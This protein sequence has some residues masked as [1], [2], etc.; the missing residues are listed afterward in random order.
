M[1]ELKNALEKA[2]EEAK[3][4]INRYEWRKSNGT[5][6]RMMDMSKDELQK[7][8]DH[9]WSMLYNKSRH[10]PGKV[11]LRDSIN[12]LG[13]A[14]LTELFIRFLLYECDIENM[15]TKQ[16]I[17]IWVSEVKRNSDV[18][19]SDYITTLFSNIRPEFS[20]IKI[21]DLVEGCLNNLGVVSR[22]LITSN[23][24]LSQGIWFTKDELD[25][26]TEYDENGVRRSYFEVMKERL[27][28]KDVKLRRDSKGF[29]Y[30]EFRALLMLEQNNKIA[31]LPTSTLNL[32]KDKII[33]MLENELSYHIEKWTNLIEQLKKVCEYK[34][35]ELIKKEY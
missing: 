5:I 7:A 27:M 19:N 21:K 32:F 18:K 34:E 22:K 10:T 30:N 4:D 15:K 20:K 29:S 9:C 14:C 16:D 6:I 33:F 31:N 12:A 17:L 3:N 28:M 26:L 35:F 23:F 13:T 1:S 24:L 25:D 8:Y 2:L 11:I